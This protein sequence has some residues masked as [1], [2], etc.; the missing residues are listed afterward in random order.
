[1]TRKP[2]IGI[3]AGEA[4]NKYYPNAPKM[5]GQQYTYI[6]AVE[7]AGG[8]PIILPIVKDEA[9]M[10]Q[11]FEQCDGLLLAGGNDINPQSYH[12]EPSPHTK[13][14]HQERDSQELMLARWAVAADKPLLAICRG[15]QIL[16]TAQGGTLYQDIPTE[17]PEADVH[18]IPDEASANREH[19]LVH[20]L[21]V[22]PKS[23]LADIL[24]A[25]TIQTNAYHHQALKTLGTGIVV[26]SRTPDEV[27]E[28]VEMP[29]QRFA[30]GVQSHPESL[31]ADIEPQW[32][33][34]FSA[35][36]AAARTSR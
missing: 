23:R 5:Y 1:M 13:H 22:E 24:Q 12:A 30:I 17:L 2:L 14:I 21:I 32:R 7:R 4:R 20:A 33:K 3:T 11:L 26:T 19:Q 16:N 27:I 34:L 18:E 31:E 36:I 6:E 28:S 25:T 10:R 29:D 15:M 8:V 35:F 9:V